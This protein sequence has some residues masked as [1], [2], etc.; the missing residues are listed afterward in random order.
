[1]FETVVLPRL[2]ALGIG[3]GVLVQRKI[4][5]F[6]AGESHVEEKLFDLTRRGHVPEVGIT[7]N[8]ATISLRII[9]HAASHAEA[10]AQIAPVETMIRERL[11]CLVFGVE[12]E[13]LQDIVI[14]LLR[15]K[16]LT[17]ATA[18]SLTARAWSPIA[19]ARCRGPAT[20]SAAAWWRTRPRP[21]SA[22]SACQR[23]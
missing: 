3:G 18:E 19:W 17:V 9:A 21:R 8:D 6:G 5:V 11:G 4:N 23:R 7:V 16:N 13:E 14:R 2:L 22:C 1:M 20:S 12:V 15:E 10:D